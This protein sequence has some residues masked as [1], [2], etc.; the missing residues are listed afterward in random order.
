[1]ALLSCELSLNS[2]GTFELIHKYCYFWME[3]NCNSNVQGQMQ[4]TG[5]YDVLA[6]DV[7][8]S[9]PYGNQVKAT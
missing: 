1:M 3:S 4:Y 5:S 9:N 2:N 8:F 7:A 6:L